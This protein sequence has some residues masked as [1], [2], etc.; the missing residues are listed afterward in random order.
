MPLLDAD[1]QELLRLSDDGHLFL[2]LE[3]MQAIRE[4]YRGL[5][6]EPT[7]AELETLAQTWSEHCVHK[8]LKSRIRLSRRRVIRSGSDWLPATEAG[9]EATRADLREPA[10]GYHRPSDARDWTS[11]WCLSVFEDN[12]GIIEFDERYGVAFKVE[13]HNHPSAL[14]PYGGAATGIGGCIRDILGCGLGAR[15]DRQR[16]TCSVSPRS[17]LDPGARSDGVAPSA[18]AA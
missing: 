6:R 7:D 3:E 1:D 16:P 18:A 4:H 10:V 14:E 9:L 13:T 15:A 5:G 2:N 12:A 8:T 11:D 17:G